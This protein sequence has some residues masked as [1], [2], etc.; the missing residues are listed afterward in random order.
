MKLAKIKNGKAAGPDGIVIEMLRALDKL[1]TKWVTIL[2][3]KIYDDGQF[4]E[5]MGK[6]VFVTL[7]KKPGAT[8]CEN[9]RTNSLISHLTKVAL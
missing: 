5:A 1:G 3:S 4:P 6:S 9:F 2:A 7:P 8:K